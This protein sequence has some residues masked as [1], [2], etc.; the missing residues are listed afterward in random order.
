[1]ERTLAVCR[2]VY[3]SM[4]NWRKHDFEVRGQSPNYYE[5]KKA[6]P[7]W[8]KS[9]PELREVYSQTLQDVVKRVDLAFQ[10]FFRRIQAGETPG[11]PRLKG[12]GIYDSFTFTQSGYTLNGNTLTLFNV[13]A[14]KVVL[15]RPLPCL[16][17]REGAVKTLTI[18]RR[19]GKW[20]HPQAGT[21]L[22]VRDSRRK[23]ATLQRKHWRGRGAFPLRHTFG[24]FYGGKPPLLPPRRKGSG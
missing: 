21:R 14:I 11:Y 6:L 9:H 18:R 16:H 1:M 15:H 2:D 5:Q 3:N 23:P 13:G 7:L 22:L 19:G 10:A 20:Y 12:E 24:R 17:G 4:V 8:K